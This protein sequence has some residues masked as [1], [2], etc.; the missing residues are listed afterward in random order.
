MKLEQ[1]DLA[2]ILQ[3]DMEG[4]TFLLRTEVNQKIYDLQIEKSKCEEN[5][6]RM[7]TIFEVEEE[8]AYQ[9]NS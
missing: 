1:D 9:K 7:Q 8:I 6:F 4:M 5:V 2:R 3:Y